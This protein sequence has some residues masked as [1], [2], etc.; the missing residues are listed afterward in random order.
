MDKHEK[1]DKPH[2]RIGTIGHVDHSKTELIKLIEEVVNKQ[3]KTNNVLQNKKTGETCE[4][5]KNNGITLRK[6]YKNIK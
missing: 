2:V 6:S 1:I 5:D 4:E 3:L